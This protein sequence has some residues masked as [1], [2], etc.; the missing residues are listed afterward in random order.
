MSGYIARK[1]IP[2]TPSDTV[3]L[4]EGVCN[5]LLV[6]SAGTANLDEPGGTAR[7]NVPLQ[8]GYNPIAVKRVRTGGTAS[9]IWALY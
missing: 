6:A 5:G 2:V 1:F 9:G 8:A 7:S 4:A 3:D